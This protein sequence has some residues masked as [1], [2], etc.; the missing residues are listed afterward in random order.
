MDEGA[1]AASLPAEEGVLPP[2]NRPSDSQNAS[3]G[4]N[5]GSFSQKILLTG[6]ELWLQGTAPGLRSICNLEA[7]V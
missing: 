1:A 2:A 4:R 3:R 6:P 7:K 5:R